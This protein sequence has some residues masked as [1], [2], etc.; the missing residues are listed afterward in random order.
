MDWLDD[1]DGAP[2]GPTH[3]TADGP[4]EK[5][6][7]GRPK[8]SPNRPKDP[9]NDLAPVPTARA[10][11]V[12]YDQGKA[13]KKALVAYLSEMTAD[14]QEA[15]DYVLR[16]MRG[17][18]KMLTYDREGCPVEMPPSEK[19]RQWAVDVVLK[20]VAPAP[21]HLEV[22]VEGQVDL[23]AVPPELAGD[24]R[25]VEA[26]ERLTWQ[27]RQALLARARGEEV[28]ETITGELVSSE[29]ADPERS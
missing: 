4:G 28:P 29:P 12:P 5:R 26:L 23:R 8:G 6:R 11:L 20:Y 19:A 21:K 7:P 22:K 17:E 14:G 9:F 2:T 1:F 16:V 25:E 3:R 15:A 18:E 27:K 24:A 13:N 10:R